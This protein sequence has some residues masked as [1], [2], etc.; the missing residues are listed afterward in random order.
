[1]VPVGNSLE[2]KWPALDQYK[3]P[4]TAAGV[5]AVCEPMLGFQLFYKGEITQRTYSDAALDMITFKELSCTDRV[6]D[7]VS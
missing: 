7:F 3:A 1:M 2:F 5:N 6:D 4:T